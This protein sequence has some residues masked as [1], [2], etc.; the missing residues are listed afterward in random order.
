MGDFRPVSCCNIF[1]KI[2]TK[3]LAG[4]LS[5]ILLNLIDKAP[6]TFVKGR[7]IVENIYLAQES[8]RGYN[9]KRTPPKCTMK[10]DIRK[11]Y[12]TISWEFLEKVLLALHF[13][14]IF[15]NGS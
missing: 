7:S 3:L 10:I 4:R 1:Y 13:P 12:D 15:V 5:Y 2:I 11:A 9:R 8:I 14:T 6:S